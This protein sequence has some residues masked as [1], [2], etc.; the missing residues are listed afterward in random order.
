[1]ARHGRPSKSQ[2]QSYLRKS[3]Y[4]NRLTLNQKLWGVLSLLWL[5]IVVL[6]TASAWMHRSDLL[7]Q[8]KH[9]LSQQVDTAMGVISYFQ[10]KAAEKALSVADA[11]LQA[12]ESMRGLRYGEGREGYFG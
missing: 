3:E 2:R 5:G 6:V 9:T 11:K 1:M 12:L 8:R 4:M 10:K 7:D